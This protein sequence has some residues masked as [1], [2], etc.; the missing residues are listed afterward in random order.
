VRVVGKRIDSMHRVVHSLLVILCVG[1]SSSWV[2]GEGGETTVS[3]QSVTG[4][5]SV[6]GGVSVGRLA[7]SDD[8][9]VDRVWSQYVHVSDTNVVH[10]LMSLLSLGC[11]SDT[12][13]AIPSGFF[14][15]VIFFDEGGTPQ[16]FASVSRSAG[17]VLITPCRM[18]RSGSLVLYGESTLQRNPIWVGLVYGIMVRDRFDVVL[19]ERSM[20]EG[21]QE[22]LEETMF[23]TW[24][25]TDAA[26]MKALR[27]SYAP[28]FLWY[29][30]HDSGRS[31]AK[32]RAIG[33]SSVTIPTNTDK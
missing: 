26:D 29:S 24:R 21:M 4:E 25:G 28:L 6:L 17:M 5:S 18:N 1:T 20:F 23:D 2:L 32:E 19:S 12:H 11:A 13:T 33:N 27:H 3:L 30:T 10:S 14:C 22:T 7:S 9:S 15:R 31:T 8:Q 16:K